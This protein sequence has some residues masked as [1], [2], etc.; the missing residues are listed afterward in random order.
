[1]NHQTKH[2]GNGLLPYPVIAAASKG[3]SSAMEIVLHHYGSY[4]NK[5]SM[6]TLFDENGNPHACMDEEMRRRLE[7]KLITKVLT[8]RAA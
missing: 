3:D 4:I 7:M 5:L 6:R 1:M 2:K 8:F